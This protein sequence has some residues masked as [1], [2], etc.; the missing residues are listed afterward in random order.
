MRTSA[1]LSA[2]LMFVGAKMLYSY[3]EHDLLPGLPSMPVWLSLLIIVLL[4]GSS[5]AA[6]LWFKEQQEDGRKAA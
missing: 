4:L 3:V 2:V 5:V 1:L 6:S